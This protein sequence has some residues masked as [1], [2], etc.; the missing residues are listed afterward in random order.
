MTILGSV[1]QGRF[2]GGCYS[3]KD[4]AKGIISIDTLF[5]LALGW[6]MVVSWFAYGIVHGDFCIRGVD[7]IG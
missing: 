4:D 3:Y 7:D 6:K 5:C 1:V 2:K